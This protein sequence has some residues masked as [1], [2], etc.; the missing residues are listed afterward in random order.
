MSTLQAGAQCAI[1]GKELKQGEAFWGMDLPEHLKKD[2]E[3]KEGCR[4]IEQE[5]MLK[6][7]DF[8]PPFLRVEKMMISDTAHHS[9]ANSKS[10]GM[11]HITTK[12]THGHYN[13][14]IYLAMCGW[15]M[16]SSASVHLAFLFPTTAPQVVEANKVRPIL[17][18]NAK[19]IVW[20][21]SV[22]GTPFFVETTVLKKKMQLLVV[23]TKITFGNI[24][25]GTI[26]ELKLVLTDKKSIWAA[27]EVPG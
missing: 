21:P 24:L 11:G 2:Y 18:G 22:K 15:L 19:N 23:M 13:D 6:T 1:M 10:L 12:D 7:I 27:K 8:H 25:Y 3:G 14:T 16:A 20:K 9:V 17:K 26:E 5:E 4:L